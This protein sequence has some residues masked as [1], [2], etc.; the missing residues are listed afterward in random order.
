MFPASDLAPAAPRAIR[1]SEHGLA[2]L[3]PTSRVPPSI[4]SL[5]TDS[6]LT[7]AL[8][9]SQSQA[10]AGLPQLLATENQLQMEVT[11]LPVPGTSEHTRWSTPTP[12]L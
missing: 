5:N 9:E 11:V 8:P 3:A 2:P 7:R 1:G 6:P 4:T 12:F 10:V